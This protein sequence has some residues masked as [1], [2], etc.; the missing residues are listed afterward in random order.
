MTRSPFLH[1]SNSVSGPYKRLTLLQRA[2]RW[3]SYWVAGVS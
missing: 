3:L 1:W 2:H